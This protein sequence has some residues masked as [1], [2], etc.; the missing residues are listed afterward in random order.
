[1]SGQS[2]A[3]QR[4]AFSS[5]LPLQFCPDLAFDVIM[6]FLEAIG[7][8][9]LRRETILSQEVD[10]TVLLLLYEHVITWEN[11]MTLYQATGPDRTPSQTGKDN[12]Q[13]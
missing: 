12:A 4:H 7:A 5:I 6:E 13:G 9:H 3:D 10:F 11:L 1:M 2:K 8:W